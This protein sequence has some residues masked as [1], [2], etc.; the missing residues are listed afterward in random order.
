MTVWSGLADF[1]SFRNTRWG[2]VGRSWVGCYSGLSL[3]LR[4]LS[5]FSWTIWFGLAF[6]LLPLGENDPEREDTGR[7][8]AALTAHDQR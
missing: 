4:F 2:L 7:I 6:N 8:P 5:P 1:C 3:R